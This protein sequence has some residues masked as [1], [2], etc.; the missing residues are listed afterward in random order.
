MVEEQAKTTFAE[1]VTIAFQVIAA[2]LVNH[3]YHDQLGMSV[4]R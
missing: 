1:L 4:I 3:N 2:E